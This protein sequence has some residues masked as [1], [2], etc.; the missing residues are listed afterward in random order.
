MEEL[1]YQ[2]R[3]GEEGSRK[4]ELSWRQLKNTTLRKIVDQEKLRKQ[5]KTLV[6]LREKIPKRV[7]KA[8]K[9][10][11]IR[12]GWTDPLLIEAWS[13]GGYLMRIARDSMDYYLSLHQHLMGLASSE[14]PWSYAQVEI[15]HHVEELDLIRGS[16]DSR[17]QAILSLYCYLRDGVASNWH[18]SS[19]QYKRNV[20]AMMIWSA[21]GT[22][23]SETSNPSN[24]PLSCT[25]CQT[26]LHAGGRG[27]CPWRTLSDA[28]A[29]KK[30]AAVL[31]NWAN[32]VC[33]PL[34][35]PD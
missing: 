33:A 6:K 2:G 25:K 8:C 19:L 32:G 20:D 18:S 9:N 35:P 27:N 23:R 4:A 21:G 14:V 12:A 5:I 22:G 7:V 10:G 1:V 17:I 31:S 34:C 30:G 13:Q 26:S 11:L 16:A 29:K 28:A 24:T 15:D 3:G